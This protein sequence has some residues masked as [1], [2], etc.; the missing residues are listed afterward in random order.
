M[1]WVKIKNCL[2]KKFKE[3]TKDAFNLIKENWTSLAEEEIYKNFSP[4]KLTKKGIL[5][6]KKINEIDILNT[7]GLFNEL[8]KKIN[9]FLGKDF[10]QKI[11]FF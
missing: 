7:K 11:K 5:V 8:K 2:P 4:E 6:L 10:I 1:D 3:P 9:S